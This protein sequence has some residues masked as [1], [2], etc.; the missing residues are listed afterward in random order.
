[1]RSRPVPRLL[2]DP[3]QR[4]EEP[5]KLAEL[6]SF[7]ESDGWKGIARRIQESRLIE[8]ERCLKAASSRTGNVPAFNAGIAE[9]LRRASET[10]P[11]QMLDEVANTKVLHEEEIE[12]DDDKGY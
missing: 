6:R 7:F 3:R 12:P 5:E 4:P 11:L 9:G 8:I 2:V 1:M 10:I